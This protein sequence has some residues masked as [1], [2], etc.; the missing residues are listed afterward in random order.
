MKPLVLLVIAG[1]VVAGVVMALKSTLGPAKF[2]ARSSLGTGSLAVGA[3]SEASE[4]IAVWREPR[5]SISRADREALFAGELRPGDT[6]RV[7]NH[8]STDVLWVEIEGIEGD[9]SGWIRS[10]PD[11]PV[12]ASRIR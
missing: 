11:A 12:H 3:V 2:S 10:P 1:V 9:L 5:G 4:R 8:V 7:R 6:F